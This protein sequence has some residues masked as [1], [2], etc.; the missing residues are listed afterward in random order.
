M[1]VSV[2]SNV[3]PKISWG[4]LSISGQ[5]RWKELHCDIITP[6]PENPCGFE[7]VQNTSYLIKEKLDYAWLD[8]FCVNECNILSS[9]RRVQEVEGFAGLMPH[10]QRQAVFTRLLKILVVFSQAPEH[11]QHMV[12][13]A[14]AGTLL[15][16]LRHGGV[17]PWDHDID[18]FIT[19]ASA[20][21]L[22]DHMAELPS[23]ITMQH[24]RLE[25]KIKRVNND[26]LL[27]LRDLNSCYNNQAKEKGYKHHNG[28]Q[29]DMFD[30]G[31]M[32]KREL[33]T[34]F[35][36]KEI[37]RTKLASFHSM[38]IPIPADPKVIEQYFDWHFGLS[39]RLMKSCRRG[40]EFAGASSDEACPYPA[41]GG[42]QN[43]VQKDG[44]WHRQGT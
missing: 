31:K 19:T 20:N 4:S 13:C 3:L 16:L 12:W 5:K 18:I 41:V 34:L 6:L 24:L 39:P 23:D 1:H 26:V 7:V 9:C 21:Y 42:A 11:R 10:I 36:E 44:L 37:G 43:L 35:N 27:T 28:L 38:M 32:W 30:W 40:V 15:G 14:A 33:G 17:I 2:Y 25:P 8:R 22:L 29:V